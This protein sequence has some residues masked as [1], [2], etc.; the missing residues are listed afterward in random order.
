MPIHDPVADYLTRIRNALR[1]EHPE[2]T[3]PGSRLKLEITQILVNE[4]YIDGSEFSED[5]RQGEIHIRLKY[6]PKGKPAISGLRRVSKP[7]LRTFV[8]RNEVPRVLEGLGVAILSTSKGILTDREARKAGVGGE[9]LCY[10][11]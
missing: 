3:I 2:V 6:G 5:S 9:V 10:V 11:W 7:G 4:G 1:A 8:G